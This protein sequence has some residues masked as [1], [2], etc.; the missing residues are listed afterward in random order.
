MK[1]YFRATHSSIG[2][3]TTYV[4]EGC[5]P[6]R[7]HAWVLTFYVQHIDEIV[8]TDGIKDAFRYINIDPAA[9]RPFFAFYPMSDLAFTQSER[10]R[11][12]RVKSPKLPGSGIIYDLA[13][14]D[15]RYLSHVR[16]IGE[17]SGDAKGLITIG[18][19][20][21]EA[22]SPGEVVKWF[23]TTVCRSSS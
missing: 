12:I 8:N 3:I 11:Q 13:E 1:K 6:Y 22:Q 4:F 17:R 23:E 14:F 16:T 9:D 15:V 5:N 2:T 19:E 10:F 21:S 20:P 18:V 7:R